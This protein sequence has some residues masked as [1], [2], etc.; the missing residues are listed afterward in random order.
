M[1]RQHAVLALATVLDMVVGSGSVGGRTEI[2]AELG[3]VGEE[4][5]Y[6][7]LVVEDIVGR[8]SE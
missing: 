6:E 1:L 7:E 8:G 5:R 3:T 4:F 2:G